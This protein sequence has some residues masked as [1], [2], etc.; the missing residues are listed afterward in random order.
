MRRPDR[1]PLRGLMTG[2]AGEAIGHTPED[3]H[4]WRSDRKKGIK[5]VLHKQSGLHVFSRIKHMKLLT[6]Y[7]SHPFEAHVDL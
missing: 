4:L 5:L 7:D 3:D 6:T 2:S 1:P